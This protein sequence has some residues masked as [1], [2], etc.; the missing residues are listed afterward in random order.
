MK[1]NNQAETKVSFRI[2]VDQLIFYR[3]MADYFFKYNYIAKPNLSHLARVCLNMVGRRYSEYE[4]R[5]I[6][7]YLRKR[8]DAARGQGTTQ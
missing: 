8:F 5:T 3:R 4:D 6:G 1:N 7:T 2:K